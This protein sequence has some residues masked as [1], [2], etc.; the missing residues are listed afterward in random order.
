MQGLPFLSFCDKQAGA[1]DPL[2]WLKAGKEALWAW[3]AA[4]ELLLT[5]CNAQQGTSAGKLLL[6]KQ[7]TLKLA[8]L[9]VV[10]ILPHTMIFDA[11]F[12]RQA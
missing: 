8:L 4:E 5:A 1:E 2:A 9:V 3:R 11:M 10:F 7:Q 12:E 6:E